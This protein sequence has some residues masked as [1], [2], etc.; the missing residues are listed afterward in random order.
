[1]ATASLID[2]EPRLRGALENSEQPVG[3]DRSRLSTNVRS[4]E[5]SHG[6]LLTIEPGQ[7]WVIGI[8]ATAALSAA[9]RQ[10]IV[11]SNIVIYDRSL[12]PIVAKTL[13]PGG[14]A[15][16]ALRE[17]TVER[18]V[19]FARDGWSVVRL[20]DRELPDRQRTA[21]LRALTRQLSAANNSADARPLLFLL[22][23]SASRQRPVKQIDP[24]MAITTEREDLTVVFLAT[25]IAP[26]PGFATA[27]LNGLAG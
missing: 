14:Y 4:T 25:D 24:K 17:K 1:M 22:D 27:P 5:L 11:D 26:K 6:A 2:L 3:P 16:P 7:I 21:H 18:C 19:R 10:A 9:Q 13:P 20:V 23:A 8:S 12:E 15:E